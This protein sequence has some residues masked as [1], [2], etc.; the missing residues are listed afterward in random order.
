MADDC[1][2]ISTFAT[3]PDL[4]GLDHLKELLE[5]ASKV[6]PEEAVA[7]TPI[8]LLATAGVR[9]LPDLQRNKLLAE[10][11]SYTRSTTNFQLPDCDLYVQAISGE[12]EGLY[13]W[14]AAN[15]LLGG[16][17]APEDHAHG[18]GHHT[19]GFL[20]MGGASAQIAFAPNATETERHAEDLTL[21]RMRTLDGAAAEYKVFVTT[22]LK[23]GV[24]EARKRYV[25]ALLKASGPESKELKDPCLP[26]GLSID[27]PGDVLLPGLKTIESKSPLIIGTGNFDE[28]LKRTYPLLEKDAPCED[29]PCLLHGVHVPAIDFDV[30]HFV[31]VS[32]YWHTTHEVFEFGHTDKAY[33]FNT[34]QE[35][36]SEFCSQDWSVITEGIGKHKWGKK[37]D[38]KTAVEV[39]FKASWLINV[40]HEGIGIPRIG[41]ENT[42]SGDHNG[43]KEILDNA[44]SK[45]FTDSF[46]A[47]DKIADTEVSWTLG[48]MVLYASSQVP[49]QNAKL[50]VGFG[51][52]TPGVPIPSD[53]QFAGSSHSS[54]NASSKTTTDPSASSEGDHWHDTLFHNATPRRV[55]GFLL[56]LIIF[57]IAV[58]LLCGRD[59]RHRL[60]RK[61]TSSPSSSSSF[62]RKRNFLGS[63]IPSLFRSATS[64]TPG[65]Y[66]RVLEDGGVADFELGSADELSDNEHSD[67]SGAS[68]TSGWATPRVQISHHSG[69]ADD[70]SYFDSSNNTGIGGQGIGLGLGLGPIGGLTAGGGN[71][72]SRSG[73]VGRTDSRERLAG[74]G[75]G[76]RKSRRGSPSR[77]KGMGKVI[78]D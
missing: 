31:G 5:H 6:I 19:Y 43:T 60:Y 9:L 75:E 14:I 76:G 68:K 32:E 25:E 35:R 69:L 11:C 72:M 8:F 57:S 50:P 45:G 20:D 41:V 61:F 63:K 2:G 24:N 66:E 10:I 47:V 38:E 65:S 67:S 12:T 3:R 16:F 78:E 26:V 48:R 4:V 62:P 56:F 40:L 27:I 74:M 59:R 23:F 64:S 15:Y 70:S 1:K 13:G 30:N 53:F 18:K 42:Q 17:D 44:K 29:E 36:V 77:F 21:L 7:E 51:S 54:T 55:P 22:W 52:N 71:A 49:P 28:C 73:L 37:V 39:C 46:Q 33:D 34:Y 58:F